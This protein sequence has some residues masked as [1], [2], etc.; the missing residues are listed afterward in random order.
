[1][2]FKLEP[3]DRVTVVE[4]QRVVRQS[5]Q[6]VGRLEDKRRIGKVPETE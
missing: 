3:K 2:T 4:K 6:N 1:M 5:G